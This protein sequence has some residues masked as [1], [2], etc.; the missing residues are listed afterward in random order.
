MGIT[1]SEREPCVRIDEFPTSSAWC[2]MAMSAGCDR[3]VVVWPPDRQICSMAHT[4]MQDYG[5]GVL[6]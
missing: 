2:K 6:H 5:I 1:A 4:I 3:K